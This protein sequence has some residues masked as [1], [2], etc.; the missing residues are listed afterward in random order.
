M[1]GLSVA[2]YFTILMTFDDF[3]YDQKMLTDKPSDANRLT[4]KQ[5]ILNEFK[6]IS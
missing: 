2:F 3:W 6:S 4:A 5:I 1:V